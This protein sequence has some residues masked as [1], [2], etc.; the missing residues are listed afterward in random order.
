[1]L[2]RRSEEKRVVWGIGAARQPGR[3]ISRAWRMRRPWVGGS[4]E[5]EIAD[6]GVELGFS[7]DV[8]EA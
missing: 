5:F 2:G 4:G 3:R 8:L 7:T 1:M 6:L